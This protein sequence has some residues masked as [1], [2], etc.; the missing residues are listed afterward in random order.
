MCQMRNFAMIRKSQKTLDSVALNAISDKIL[1]DQKVE[2][3][4][5]SNIRTFPYRNWKKF[6]KYNIKDEIK[7]SL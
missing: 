7:T 6:I 4:S 2:Y 3:P 1:K 5:E